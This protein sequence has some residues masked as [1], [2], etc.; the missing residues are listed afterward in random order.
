MKNSMKKKGALFALVMLL[1]S[2]L[3]ASGS[4]AESATAE[5]LTGSGVEITFVFSNTNTYASNQYAV[6]I[7]DK[8]GT[9]V[10]TLFVSNFAG[11]DSPQNPLPYLG[12]KLEQ[13]VVDT[14]T[15]ATPTFG[16]QRHVWDLTDDEGAT[17]PDGT[18]NVIIE[19]GMY[20]NNSVVYTAPVTI[21][22]EE[23]ASEGTP[24]YTSDDEQ[25]RF[26]LSDVKA[27]YIP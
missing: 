4:N 2:L 1:V 27:K 15:G 13:D 21:G 3:V 10:K 6:W 11:S 19:G 8:E 14:V 18:Y 17:V 7:E 24:E 12:E 16:D 5:P 25:Y 23:M 9:V 22:G 26:M 20:V